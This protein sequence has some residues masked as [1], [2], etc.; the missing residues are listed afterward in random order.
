[1]PPFLT[2][3]TRQVHRLPTPSIIALC[4]LPAT[5]V[6]LP[7]LSYLDYIRR[8]WFSVSSHNAHHPPPRCLRVYI[9]STFDCHLFESQDCISTQK[10]G[11]SSF[12]S[13]SFAKRRFDCESQQ[14]RRLRLLSPQRSVIVNSV[15][16][17]E[18]YRQWL[19][20]KGDRKDILLSVWIGSGEA[21]PVE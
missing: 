3:I 1:M 10:A 2:L 14:R 17:H 13:D 6:H 19:R 21:Y 11:P 12:C 16:N 15:L 8:E 9:Q 18:L 7:I 20:C 5:L 4:Q